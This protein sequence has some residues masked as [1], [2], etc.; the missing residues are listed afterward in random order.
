MF[1]L[2]KN[3]EFCQG[4]QTKKPQ[5]AVVSLNQG[6]SYLLFTVIIDIPFP[7]VLDVLY[8]G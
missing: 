6:L 1:E 5:N 4:K 3:N 8:R 2:N 7:M